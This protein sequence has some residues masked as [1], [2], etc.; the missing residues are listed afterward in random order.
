MR[1]C[2]HCINLSRSF[3]AQKLDAC[4]TLIPFGGHLNKC[5]LID[6][7][8]KLAPLPKAPII[9]NSR[10]NGKSALSK[11]AIAETDIP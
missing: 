4:F 9:A 7:K 11:C 8:G 5:Q 6:T 3:D 1:S 10:G 2:V